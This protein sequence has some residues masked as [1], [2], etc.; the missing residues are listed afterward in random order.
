MGVIWLRTRD[1][2]TSHKI[3]PEFSDLCVLL[4]LLCATWPIYLLQKYKGQTWKAK[5]QLKAFSIPFH[6]ESM[7]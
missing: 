3:L 2:S 7:L 6:L 5:K 4:L 1:G